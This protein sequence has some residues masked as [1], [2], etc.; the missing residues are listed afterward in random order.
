VFAVHPRTLKRLEEFGLFAA[1]SG[2]AGIRLTEPLSYIEFMNLVMHSSIAISD[3][4]GVQEETTC[5]GIPCVT[6][7]EHRAADYRE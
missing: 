3:S 2:C 7:A 6:L 5:L 1:L 4:G